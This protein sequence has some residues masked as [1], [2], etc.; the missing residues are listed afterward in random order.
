MKLER[1]NVRGF[2][3]LGNGI[4]E[5]GNGK[6]ETIRQLNLWLPLQNFFGKRDVEHAEWDHQ[7]AMASQSILR[8]TLFQVLLGKFCE[9]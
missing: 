4:P 3:L 1:Y 8:M 6:I 2:V 5:I 7:K 9:W